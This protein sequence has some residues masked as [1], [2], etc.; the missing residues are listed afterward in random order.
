MSW[1]VDEAGKRDPC[2][3]R[4][5]NAG[6]HCGSCGGGGDKYSDSNEWYIEGGP[7]SGFVVDL[8]LDIL[9]DE[10]G[11]VCVRYIWLQ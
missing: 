5:S 4:M 9:G 6:P 8:S 11:D 2:L 10:E 1:S 3:A 7:F